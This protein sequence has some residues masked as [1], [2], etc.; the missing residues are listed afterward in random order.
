MEVGGGFVFRYTKKY[1]E[2]DAGSNGF[3]FR[4]H[5]AVDLDLLAMAWVYIYVCIDRISLKTY[6]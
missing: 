1:V 5:L 4:V 3:C 6:M 2:G